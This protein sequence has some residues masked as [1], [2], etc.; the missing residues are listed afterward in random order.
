[1]DIQK[2]RAGRWL[3]AEEFRVDGRR[4]GQNPA[5]QPNVRIAGNTT[6]NP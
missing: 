5:F 1:V 6:G 4:S 3:A 2:F